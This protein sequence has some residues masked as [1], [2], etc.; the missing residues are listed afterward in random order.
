M[1]RRDVIHVTDVIALDAG[2]VPKVVHT[3][4]SAARRAGESTPI[5]L[6]NSDPLVQGG[7]LLGLVKTAKTLLRLR[8]LTKQ[9][10][11]SVVFHCIWSPLFLLG[12]PLVVL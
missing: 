7:C 2:G 1:S 12:A 6:T 11:G 3:L 10:S 5:V 9:Q 8:H 4:A